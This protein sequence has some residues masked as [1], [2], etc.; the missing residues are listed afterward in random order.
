MK[1]AALLELYCGDDR[2][3]YYVVDQSY[4]D[5]LHGPMTREEADKAALARPYSK[6]VL[7]PKGQDKHS[8][9]KEG[10]RP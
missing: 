7:N 10:V 9:E 3:I 1:L 6:V 5:V 4:G 8:H 2:K